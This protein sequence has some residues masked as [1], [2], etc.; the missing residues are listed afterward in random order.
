MPYDAPHTLSID[1]DAFTVAQPGTDASVAPGRESLR[2]RLNLSDEVR[3]PT[4]LAHLL[5]LDHLG[6]LLW[7]LFVAPH[8][9]AIELKELA[10]LPLGKMRELLDLRQIW[11]ESSEAKGSMPS[12]L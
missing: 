9:G 5:E 8:C 6:V 4:L 10:P 3:F 1:Q 7:R 2:E 12:F 11:E